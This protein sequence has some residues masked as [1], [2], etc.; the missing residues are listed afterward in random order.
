MVRK[1]FELPRKPLIADEDIGIFCALTVIEGAGRGAK[2]PKSGQLD[3]ATL[4]DQQLEAA[5]LRC[6]QQAAVL[7]TDLLECGDISGHEPPCYAD[8][9]MQL[10]YSPSQQK[11][12]QELQAVRDACIRFWPETDEVTSVAALGCL[13]SMAPNYKLSLQRAEVAALTPSQL[14]DMMI[15]PRLVQLPLFDKH[16]ASWGLYD[17]KKDASATKIPLCTTVA[18]GIWQ[19]WM[20]SSDLRSELSTVLEDLRMTVSLT[21]APMSQLQGK[22][23]E[24]FPCY[25]GVLQGS[26]SKGNPGGK[27]VE[28]DHRKVLKQLR[29]I[30]EDFRQPRKPRRTSDDSPGASKRSSKTTVG[31]SD[32]RV[33]DIDGGSRARRSGAA[34]RTSST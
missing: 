4:L 16:L 34:T 3:W 6:R 2:R 10:D 19:S 30:A 9:L 32:E 17:K 13:N 33:A 31:A 1:I 24:C 20:W 29:T 8:V 23:Q 14:I 15:E 11:A 18:T 25:S 21:K 5:M 26:P 28:F 12:R 7:N 22:L 27:A